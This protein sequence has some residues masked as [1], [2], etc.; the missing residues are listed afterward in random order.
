MAAEFEALDRELAASVTD[1]WGSVLLADDLP[2]ATFV[3]AHGRVVYANR[4]ACEGLGDPERSLTVGSRALDLVEPDDRELVQ[5]R[6]LA[7][8]AGEPVLARDTRLRGFDGTTRLYEMVSL[9]VFH[10]DQPAILSV[11]R[12]VGEIREAQS[13]AARAE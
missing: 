6:M 10:Q 2:D 13:R 8:S 11:G 4:A 5:Q 7:V 9:R 3:L 1:P 12:A